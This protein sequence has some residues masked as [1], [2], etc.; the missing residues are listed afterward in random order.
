MKFA[1]TSAFAR[2]RRIW[3]PV[4]NRTLKVFTGDDRLA[5][6]FQPRL[7]M[8]ALERLGVAR[9]AYDHERHHSL[10]Y[11]GGPDQEHKSFKMR[12]AQDSYDCRSA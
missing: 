1:V 12:R 11:E 2:M 3:L 10:H 7:L 5:A 8:S 4:S 6:R 9:P